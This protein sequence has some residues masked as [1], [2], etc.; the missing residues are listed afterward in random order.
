MTKDERNAYVM[1]WKRN[2]PES[3]RETQR[4]YYMRNREERLTHSRE[5]AK[6][7]PEK[8]REMQRKWY[9][10]HPEKVKKYADRQRAKRQA[11]RQARIAAIPPEV[12]SLDDPAWMR[13]A[14]K[15]LELKQWMLAR[16]VGCHHTFISQLERGAV[17]L[18]RSKHRDKI[19]KVLKGVSYAEA[20]EMER[21]RLRGVTG[22]DAAGEPH[23][24]GDAAGDHA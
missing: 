6:Q 13:E 3:V 10:D 17:P 14:R 15:A 4:R 16:K 7:N 8:M 11:E 18:H 23:E 19:C 1:E 21:A 24:R 2:H 20:L 12:Y 22:S 5:W 9:R